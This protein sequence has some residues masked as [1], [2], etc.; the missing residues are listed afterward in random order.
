MWMV[1]G[2][3]AIVFTVLNLVWTL[4]N[5]SAEWFRFAGLA[6]TAL[7]VCSFYADAAGRVAA[8]DWSGLM[9]IMPTMNRALWVCTV[10][11][12]LLNCISLFKRKE[13]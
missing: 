11:S 8:E 10:I 7:T 13:S 12:I 2:T 4:N 9:D 5:K 6:L 1:F 3:G